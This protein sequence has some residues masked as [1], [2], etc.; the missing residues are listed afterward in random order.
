MGTCRWFRDTRWYGAHPLR[1]MQDTP[2]NATYGCCGCD[3]CKGN[4]ED[5]STRMDEFAYRLWATG[6][7]LTKSVWTVPQGFGGGE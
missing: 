2:C 4:F 5:I 7:D 6:W 3:D 1:Q